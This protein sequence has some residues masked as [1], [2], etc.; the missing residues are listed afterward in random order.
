ML[1]V[2]LTHLIS[3]SQ[4]RLHDPRPIIT[5]NRE[6]EATLTQLHI[7]PGNNSLQMIV[8]VQNWSLLPSCALYALLL[9]HLILSVSVLPTSSS[10]PSSSINLIRSLLD[11]GSKGTNYTRSRETPNPKQP[12]KMFLEA[13]PIKMYTIILLSAC[14]SR[15]TG[16]NPNYNLGSM[17]D[18]GSPGQTE[19]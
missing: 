13:L 2:C 7:P 6:Q 4:S 15:A 10:S 17:F 16:G 14:V 11:H 9:V 5:I 19:F 8:L 12:G 18:R 3:Y 1:L